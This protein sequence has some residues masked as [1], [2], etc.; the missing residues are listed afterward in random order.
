MCSKMKELLIDFT[1]TREQLLQSCF[2]VYKGS[3]GME[4]GSLSFLKTSLIRHKASSTS[5]PTSERSHEGSSSSLSLFT[6]F[7]RCDQCHTWSNYPSV[8]VN[9]TYTTIHEELQWWVPEQQKQI[10][11]LTSK[12]LN[13]TEILPA[14]NSEWEI[15][16]SSD[17]RIVLKRHFTFSEDFVCFYLKTSGDRMGTS[18]ISSHPPLLFQLYLGSV[19][20]WYRNYL[21]EVE[22]KKMWLVVS[23]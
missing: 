2:S 18:L 20:T 6:Q 9:S 10:I 5:L 22:K 1:K 17:T 23:H 14:W 16:N 21:V 4:D 7:N 3:S 15:G 11:C 13:N 12:S 19:S 8:L